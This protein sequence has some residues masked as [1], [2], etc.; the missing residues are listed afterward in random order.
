MEVKAPTIFGLST[1]FS[2]NLCNQ[3]L[4]SGEAVLTRAPTKDFPRATAF[5]IRIS[6]TYQASVFWI[7]NSKPLSCFLFLFTSQL[8]FCK[9]ASEPPLKSSLICQPHIPPLFVPAGVCE[10]SCMNGGRCVHPNV[11]DCPSG[12]R[13]RHCSKR[14]H[15][16]SHQSLYSL[17]QSTA[18]CN[19]LIL[20]TSTESVLLFQ[21]FEEITVLSTGT[22]KC[23]KHLMLAEEKKLRG[24][25]L[26]LLHAA[27]L[28]I[29]LWK[30]IFTVLNLK[31]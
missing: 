7:L 29:L 6:G 24:G 9:E 1:C 8:T 30:F 17:A 22:T 31:H 27:L 26:V 21:Q 25:T 19:L 10:P 18:I 3:P 14:K 16:C 11:C 20:K 5:P 23:C 2:E 15:L 4:C 28:Y 13:G 12:W